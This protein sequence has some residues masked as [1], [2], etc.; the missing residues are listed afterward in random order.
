MSSGDESDDEDL[1][2]GDVSDSEWS[3]I[4][5]G[6]P[7]GFSSEYLHSRSSDVSGNYFSLLMAQYSRSTRHY[8]APR[9][10][11]PSQWNGSP[12]LLTRVS[13][14]HAVCLLFNVTFVIGL[15][16]LANWLGIYESC[17][18]STHECKNTWLCGYVILSGV[19]SGMSRGAWAY[20]HTSYHPGS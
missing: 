20:M 16:I 10:N 15:Q 18:I 3:D 17:T 4:D 19:P 11:F 13:P 9:L 7:T 6:K 14:S 8:K 5:H 12:F 1:T 2:E